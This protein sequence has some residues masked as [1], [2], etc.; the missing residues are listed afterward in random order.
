MSTP[1]QKTNE[2]LLTSR[3]FDTVIRLGLALL[4]MIWCFQILRPFIIPVMWGIVIAVAVYPF[5]LKLCSML[6][7]RQKLA[8]A[9]YT[10][11]A[12][13]FLIAPTIMISGSLF[14]T[15]KKLAEEIQQG[16]LAIPPPDERVSEWPLVGEQ[17]YSIWNQAAS[18]LEETLNKYRSGIKKVGQVI[19]SAVAG[20]GGGVLQFILSIFISGILLA[21]SSGAYDFSLKIF[22]RLTGDRQGQQFTDL[23]VATIRNVAQG[24]L[25]I[26]ILQAVLAGIGMYLM[27]VPGW[28]FW[29]ILVLIVAVA[30]LP[31]IL[32]LGPVIGYVF[33][34]SD[35]TPAV[36]FTVWSVLVSMTDGFLKPLFLGRGM[37]TP[38]LVILLGAIGG[39]MLSGILGLFVGAI[40]LALGYELFMAWLNQEQ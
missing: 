19:I 10:L 20:A 6:G 2:Q 5:Y 7:G 39:M 13:A 33:S 1:E 31:L 26:A 38:M 28:G 23:V 27:G 17:V 8:A 40:V 16:T 3:V 34:V 29:T 36:L 32:I 35:T 15:S 18:N 24:V 37:E 22:K 30:Q 14:D 11:I 9:L 25:G 21:S 12:L 4:L